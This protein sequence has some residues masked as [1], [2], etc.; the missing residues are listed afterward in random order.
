MEAP[1]STT[2]CRRRRR[3][4]G[5]PLRQRS[6]AR[7]SAA[8]GGR[9]ACASEEP[10]HLAHE[11]TQIRHGAVVADEEDVAAHWARAMVEAADLATTHFEH[12]PALRG[13]V[14]LPPAVEVDVRHVEARGVLP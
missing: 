14:A 4:A 6:E 9:A 11:P 13:E 12:S 8:C 10:S 2:T 3:P 1:R 5:R 7:R